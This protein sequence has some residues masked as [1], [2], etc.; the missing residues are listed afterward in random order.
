MN[1]REKVLLSSIGIISITAALVTAVSIIFLYR[2]AFDQERE[3]LLQV[4]KVQERIIEAMA[5]FDA[6]HSPAYPGGP[7]A[8]TLRQVRQAYGG[9]HGSENVG[10]FVI[11]R[12]EGNVIVPLLHYHGPASPDEPKTIPFDCDSAEP[13]RRALSGESGSWIGPDSRGRIVLAAYEP[14]KRLG[15]GLVAKTELAE[16]Q[17]P[18]IRAGIYAGGIIVLLVAGG[19]MCLLF[20]T[21]PFISRVE[22]SEA[23]YR[24]LVEL[25]PDLV[26]VHTD[27]K[28][29][30]VNPAGVKLF[31]A[32]AQESLI[33]KPVLDFVHPDCRDRSRHRVKQ[34]LEKKVRT[35]LAELSVIGLDGRRSEVES[36]GTF[37]DYFG[38]PSVLL[39]M[40]DITQRKRADLEIERLNQDLRS[41]VAELQTIFEVVPIGLSIAEDP[42]GLHIRGNP[43]NERMLGVPSGTELSRRGSEDG[44][45]VLQDERP[46]TV[47]ELPMQRAVRGQTVIGQMIDLVREDGRVVQLYCSA[48][49]LLDEQGRPRGAVGAFLDVTELKNTERLLREALT[50][51][52]EGRRT[53]RALM[54]HVPEGITIAEAPDV[55]IRMV[56][57]Y[58]RD[59]LGEHHDGLRTSDVAGKWRVFHEDGTT[60]MEFED[61]PICRAVLRG[62]TV[63]NVEIVQ[64]NSMG[65]R[66]SLLCNAGPISDGDGNILGGVV[67]WRD[68]TELKQVRDALYESEQR[69]RKLFET[70]SE[71]FALHEI[72]C[73]GD[74]PCDY[75]FLEVNPAFEAQTGLKAKNLIGRTL[76]QVLPEG[77]SFWI[78]RYGR[79][80]LTGEPD[81]FERWS[82]TLGRCYDVSVFRTEPG[83]FATVFLDITERKQAEVA[84]KLSES[85]FK[86]LSQTAGRLLTSSEPQSIVNELCRQVMEHL[87]C[88]VF[89]NFLVDEQA[90][91]LHLNAC[92]GIP[93]EE[94][95]R[96]EWLNFG[97]AVCGCVALEG[98]RIVA[99]DI[100][101]TSDLRT[102]LVKSYGVQA[103]ACHPL[104]AQGLVIGTLSFGT[105][106]RPSFT[107]DELTLMKTVA[108]QVATAMERMRLIKELQRSR[109]ELELRVRE[110]TAELSRANEELRGVPSR[111]IAAQE[112]ERKRLAGELHDSIGQTLAALKFGVET[113]LSRRDKGDPYGA[114]NILDQ[115]VP[116]LQRS[117]DETRS[118]Y[119]GLRPKTLE[120]MGLVATLDWFIREFRR[121]YPDPHIEPELEVKEEEIPEDLKIALFRIIQEAL[122]NVAKHSRAEWVDLSLRAN[123]EAIE[124]TICDD[125]IGMD[126]DYILTTSTAKSLGLTGM[127]ERAELFGGRL[128]IE[129]A[130]GEG[131]AIRASWPVRSDRGSFV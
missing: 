61:L 56:S 80:A 27:G 108:D 111:L 119:M 25:S 91:M 116:T 43:A 8:A 112:E 13:M 126:L 44:F 42:H 88:Q 96:I 89:F 46:L 33:G 130:P 29:V 129:S 58:G 66:L 57:R 11:I 6:E 32:S 40:R 53:L 67:A 99:E 84:L 100:F 125:G 38:K 39:V 1:D 122:G 52:E 95:R 23:R 113:V 31:G 26:A 109:D 70:M 93:D 87:D 123:G 45:R 106:T 7:G 75:R 21:N 48:A 12:R 69:Y 62:E 47:D 83:R 24:R 127:K 64:L 36:T 118:I 18:F 30:Y 103:Y 124:L 115:F 65:E 128:D 97:V 55:R 34:V 59:I 82:K 110:R 79:V 16:I 49:P 90:G 51:A 5:A 105:K 73:K 102:E 9:H 15:V 20:I 71:G 114:M 28:L 120:E 17:K 4:V 76:R 104:M 2:A 94:V 10:E 117:I 22:E 19:S 121:L 68:V 81:H 101:N 14:I 50:E 86:L 72:I 35:P 60:P 107:P 54:E 131:T 63:K 77:E 92:S 98:R 37:I 74:L 78:E 85:R 3:R 41:K